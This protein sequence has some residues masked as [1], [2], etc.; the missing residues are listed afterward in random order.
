MAAPLNIL[1][2]AGVIDR[3]AFT[4]AAAP[5]ALLGRLQMGVLAGAVNDMPTAGEDSFFL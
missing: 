2:T 3:M 5:A 1:Y 4:C